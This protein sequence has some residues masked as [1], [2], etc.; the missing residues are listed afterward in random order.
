MINTAFTDLGAR[1][2]VTGQGKVC[3]CSSLDEA[4]TEGGEE[5][6]LFANNGG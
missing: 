2:W 3:V 5:C 1:N 4:A 6:N